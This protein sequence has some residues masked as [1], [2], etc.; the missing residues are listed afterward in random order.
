[1]TRVNDRIRAPK[2]RVVLANGDQLGVMSSRDALYKAQSLGLDLVEIAGQADPPVCKIIDYG[3]YK[4]E[5]AKLKKQKS[6]ASTRMKEVKFRVGTGQHD[7][8]IKLGR[9]EGFLDTNHK[10][11]FVLQ[12]RG[13][14]NAHKDLGFVV[15]N[16]IIEDLKTMAQVDQPPKLNGRAVAM[17]LSPLPQHQRKRKFHLF[18]GE[19]MEEDDFED[20][21]GG[22][23]EDDFDD[24]PDETPD[25]AP[26]AEETEEA[27]N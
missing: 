9:A 27:K 4:Y 13:R 7:Y 19:L 6:K 1:M 16:R 25:E 21:E 22:H 15:L 10:C 2:V 12:F 20:E 8:N 17:I 23:A 18:H 24:V 3:K 5:Q 14:E 11:R 26:A